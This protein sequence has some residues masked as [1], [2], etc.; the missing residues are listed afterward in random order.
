MR[1]KYTLSRILHESIPTFLLAGLLACYAAVTRLKKLLQ[2]SQPTTDTERDV[3]DVMDCGPMARFMVTGGVRPLIVHNCLAELSRDEALLALYG[4][5]ANPNHDRYL[6][7]LANIPHPAMDEVRKYYDVRNPTKEGV[8]EAKSK[9]K[10]LRELGKVLCIREGELVRVRDRGWVP[11]EEVRD[12]DI[13]WDGTAWVGTR[14]AVIT[15]H[16][17]TISVDGI[18]MTADHEVLT[19]HGWKR[20]DE[21]QEGAPGPQCVRPKLPSAS[22]TDVRAVASSLLRDAAEIGA[23]LCARLLSS[24]R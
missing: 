3:Y 1:G 20:A 15:G 18:R 16:G 6:Y 13:V 4:P 11:I 2:P 10:Q 19:D 8:A 22:W 12:G 9:C 14:G 21:I 24:R 17:A 5:D 23:S 7:T